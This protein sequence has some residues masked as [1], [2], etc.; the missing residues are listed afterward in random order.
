MIFA[1][2]VDFDCFPF[3]AWRKITK[4]VINEY[5]RALMKT[6]DPKGCPELRAA[7]RDTCA[8]PGVLPV[9]RSRSASVPGRKF[10]LLL[11]VQLF[12]EDFVY[13]IENPGYEKLP[14][15]S[16]AAGRR[17]NQC[18]LTKT[19]CVWTRLKKHGQRGLYYA[20]AS[21]PDWTHHAVSRRIQLLNWANEKRGGILLKTTMTA[22]S[23]IRKAIPSLQ[24]LDQEGASFIWALSPNHCHPL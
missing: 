7:S 24:G 1:S 13:A 14:M 8:I 19:A 5:D 22:N 11:L 12:D 4:E 17:I 23:D 15:I 21:V 9:L 18:L 10:L 2:R 20:V 3:S 6:G 16:G